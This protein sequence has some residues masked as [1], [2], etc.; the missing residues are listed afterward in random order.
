MESIIRLFTTEPIRWPDRA[1]PSS[2]G[3]T[4]STGFCCGTD[5]LH[6]VFRFAR[7]S[8]VMPVGGDRADLIRRIEVNPFCEATGR[9]DLIPPD[10][11][12]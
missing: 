3:W 2:T 4:A 7:V 11:D 6:H 5:H 8:Q 1:P 12:G 9:G 10:N